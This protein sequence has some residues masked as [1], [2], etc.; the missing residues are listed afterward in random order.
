MKP[1]LLIT[2]AVTFLTLS[3]SAHVNALEGETLEEIRAVQLYSE[4]ALIEMINA[5]THLDKVLADRC[6][7]VQDIE[8][9]VLDCFVH[10]DAYPGSF[11]VRQYSPQCNG[12]FY[13]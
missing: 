1:Y 12:F 7:L 2:L 9:I 3:F 5:N 8:S 10:S 6:Q 4:D 13:Q 11:L